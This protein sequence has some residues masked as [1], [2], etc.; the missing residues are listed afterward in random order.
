MNLK[1]ELKKIEN[2]KN[3]LEKKDINLIIT[4]FDDTIFCRNEQLETDE[5]LVKYRWEKWNNYIKNVVWIEKFVNKYY[6]NKEFPQTIVNKL[7]LDHDLILTAWMEEFSNAKINATGLD[8]YNYIIVEKAEL[9][10]I[11][12]IKYVINTLWFIPN[13][14]VI[15][16]DRPKFFIENKDLIEK[17]LWTKLEIMLVEMIDNKNEPKIKKID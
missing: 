3:N 4:D 12:T 15:Y 14:I 16:E 2:K 5:N 7:R 17:F 1:K 9:K 6:T 10:I 8:I 13:K 11:E